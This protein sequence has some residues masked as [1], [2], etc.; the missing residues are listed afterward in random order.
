MAYVCA[1][2]FLYVVHMDLVG[3]SSYG[4]FVDTTYQLWV[5]DC[6]PIVPCMYFGPLL[7]F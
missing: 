5:S 4:S 7:V 3:N 1:Q 6:F 2:P